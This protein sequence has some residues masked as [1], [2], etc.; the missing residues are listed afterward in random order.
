MRNEISPDYWLFQYHST[1]IAV[2]PIPGAAAIRCSPCCPMVHKSGI[3]S[4]G[5]DSL[6]HAKE[7]RVP[8][9]PNTPDVPLEEMSTPGRT[10]FE[11]GGYDLDIVVTGY[12]GKSLCH[13]NL[14][15]S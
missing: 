9:R 10:R 4:P 6:P 13:G 12:P 11:P 7:S 8:N 5:L 1:Q 14:G 3:I 15:W 2:K